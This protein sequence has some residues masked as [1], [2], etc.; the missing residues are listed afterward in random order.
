MGNSKT[1]GKQQTIPARRHLFFG[2][3]IFL[4]GAICV[5]GQAGHGIAAA[6]INVTQNDTSNNTASVT[7]TTSLSVN[8]FAIRPGSNRGDY[9]VQ[10]GLGFS[11]DVDTGVMM[12]SVAQNGRDNGEAANPGLNYCTTAFD[13]SRTGGSAGA[14]FL[15]VFNAPAGNEY[16]INVSAALFPYD[17]WLGGFARNSGSTNGG[18][19]NLFTGSPGLVLGT[20]FV[21]NGGGVS[22]VNLTNLGIDSRTSGVLLVTHGK[23]EA[24]YA[25]SQVNSNNGTW[26]VYVKDS[27]ANQAANEQD[28][29]GFV[30]IA[31]TNTSVVSGRFRGDGARLVFS[32]ATPQYNVANTGTGTWRLTIPGHSPDSGVLIISAEGGLGQN[33]DNIVSYQP[34]GDGWLIQ[35]RDLP[36]NPPSLQSP[37]GEPAV[38]FV[39]IPATATMGLVSPV[40]NAQG[41]LNA[42]VLEVSVTNSGPGNLNVQFFGRI[43]PVNPATD[44]TIIGLPDT[45]FYTG[46]LNGGQVEMFIAQTEWIITNRVPRNIAYVAHFG[47]ISQNGDIKGAGN[48]LTEWRNATN[49]MYRLESPVR[50]SLPQ[51]IPHGLAVG[52]HDQEPIGDPTGTS[53]YYNQYFGHSHYNGRDYYA[54]RYGTVNKNNFF[55][56]FSAGGMDFIVIYF[57]FDA[58]ANPAVLNWAN[59]VLQTNQ[60]R[61]AIVVTHNLG[62]TQTPVN[63]SSQGSAIYN[64][65]KG[66]ANVFM[67]LAGHVTGEGQR[68][69]TYNGNTIR[70]F[71]SD[72]QGWTNGGNGYLR[73]IEFS[74]SNNMVLF[75]TYSP[76][77]DEYQT[78]PD[79]EFWFT[80]NM[81]TPLGTNDA[82]FD[83]IGTVTN[84]PS[85][86]IA[87]LVWSNRQ[88][89][90]AYEWYAV[91]TDTA[92]N[93]AT[94]PL[95]RFA[96]APNSPPQV[97][98]QMVTVQG[99]AATNLTLTAFDPNGDTLTFRTNSFPTHG[100]RMNF[101]TNTGS[102]TYVPTRGFRGLDSFSYG[103]SDGSITSS[104]AAFY[105]NVV[106]PPDTNANGLPD[107]WE[108]FFGIS[109]PAGDDDQDGQSNVEE[110]WANTNPTNS[111]SVFQITQAARNGAGH[112]TMTWPVVGGTR[113]RV[114]Y[115]NAGPNGNFTGTFTDVVRSLNVEMPAIPYG[116]TST[117]SFV[118]DF[119]L[120][121]G[122][123]VNKARYYR[124]KI[125][126]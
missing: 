78:G 54:G 74:P 114:Q 32:G 99:D 31:K 13:Y 9:N 19:N 116:A 17:K 49:A 4:A 81:S 124:I 102:F 28:P 76:W 50:T 64:A 63:F 73:I 90:T 125:V 6:N 46:E 55:D 44:F 38:S 79:S 34:D 104:P 20:H 16:N 45:Q 126:Q 80:Y 5:H 67:M 83:L 70:T 61:R 120:T 51:G 24:N 7:V 1:M 94:G 40:N 96:T 10:I 111:S 85:G 12:V 18:A 27:G 68:T 103:A 41:Q 47:D 93:S 77:A 23:N 69:D 56:F 110:Y 71:V 117:Q 123:P 115:S 107:G 105:L 43:A 121:G 119:T 113:Y 8:G 86:G 25:T 58:N 92:G 53:I 33:Q 82:P 109:N 72:Y 22:T 30:F 3:G 75:Q 21:D 98:N 37:D 57:E 91:V 65:L 100:L 89:H 48:N 118:D 26:T 84:V 35:S 62:N 95:W 29:V 2:L 122:P 88:S 60:N 11:D 112:I 106:A 15:P 108:I 101:D 97:V 59:Q 42:P 66:N 39:F 14:F 87:S 36:N 52:N